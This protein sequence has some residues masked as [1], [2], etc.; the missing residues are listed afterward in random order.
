MTDRQLKKVV[1]KP[2]LGK[3]ALNFLI[4]DKTRRKL[5]RRIKDRART[6]DSA[7]T[8]MI[9]QVSHHSESHLEDILHICL[10]HIAPLTAP[11]ALISQA[12]YSGGSLLSRL[13]DGHSKIYAYPSALVPTT[14][15]LNFWP[16]IDLAHNPEDW[17]KILSS[18]FALKAFRAGFKPDENG[19]QRIPHMFLPVLQERI[20]LNYLASLA[21]I[22]MRDVFDAWMTACFGAW[23]NYQNHGYDKKFVSALAPGL[24]MQPE[25]VENF[26]KIYPEG[27]IIALVRDPAQWFVTV[28]RHEPKTYGDVEWAISCWKASVRAS[29]ETRKKFGDRIFFIQFESLIDRTESVMRHLANFLGIPYEDILLE[30]T[31]NG[32]PIQSVNGQTTANPNAKLQSFTESKTLDQDQRLLIEKMTA[33]DYQSVLQQLVVI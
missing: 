7:R 14:S 27:R 9:R 17:L 4:T 2:K 13:F 11:L 29:M 6:K 5:K 22:N 20:F 26:F 18:H 10:K 19:G 28:S 31:F 1:E 30:P 33:A 16:K 15:A 25:N 32:V 3:K 21:T 8:K 24:V 12:P 23:L